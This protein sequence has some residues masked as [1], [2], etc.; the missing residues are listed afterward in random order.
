MSNRDRT[1]ARLSR[2]RF[3]KNSML[4]A[5]ALA[6]PALPMRARAA[7]PLKQVS[8]TLDWIFQGPNVGFMVAREKGF[9][10]DAGLDVTL[11][12]GK[13]SGSTAQLIASKAAQFG[14]AD[15][16]VV[17]NGVAKGMG[18]KTVGSVYRRNPAA[19]MVLAD[20]AIKTPKDL[21]GKTVAITAGSAQFQQWPAFLKGAGVDES[22]IQLVNIDP[23]GVGA[24]LINNKVDA[25][26]GFA[27][28]YVPTIEIRGKKEVRVFWFADYG[29]TVVSNGIIVHEDLIKSDPELIR[30]FVAPTIKGFLYGRQHPDEAAEAV[31]IYLE[32]VD[33]II[34]KREFE[35]SWKTWVTPNTKGKPLG[36]GSDADWTS[37]VDVL[38]QYGGVASP[39]APSAIYTNEFVPSGAE[40]VP[41][42]ES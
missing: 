13:G 20:S 31:K 36:W 19:C 38:R 16:Y 15:G 26:G 42:Q 37:T 29:V 12:S 1:R 3:L 17:G 33:L 11:T 35:L 9:Y 2:R 18:I 6:A 41:P 4:A 23:A 7:G 30:A 22:K 34:T 24:A 28:G 39:P 25:I 5:G 27:Q 32:T 21:A 10:R 14:F 8:M 40:Y